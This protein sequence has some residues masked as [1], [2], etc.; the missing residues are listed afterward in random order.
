M[1]DLLTKVFIMNE[2]GALHGRIEQ[3]HD[4]DG[5]RLFSDPDKYAVDW[6]TAT[7]M[8]RMVPFYPMASP[9]NGV[10]WPLELYFH[11]GPLNTASIDFN[12]GDGKAEIVAG[13]NRGYVRVRCND[14]DVSARLRYSGLGGMEPT[15]IVENASKP[16]TVDIELTV[17]VQPGTTNRTWKLTGVEIP[18]GVAK[19]VQLST[20]IY[21]GVRVAGVST[22]PA[23]LSYSQQ[24][25]AVGRNFF[26]E[27]ICLKPSSGTTIQGKDWVE[28]QGRTGE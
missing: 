23:R 19:A 20:S 26:A 28:R 24:S 21:G 10:L 18:A 4:G 5:K 16:T 15:V 9:P 2:D 12:T 27:D 3:V 6:D 1:T 11:K 25:L 22:S 17:P 13:D 8:C 14:P 7:G